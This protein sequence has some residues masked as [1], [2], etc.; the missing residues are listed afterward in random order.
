[1]GG[2]AVGLGVGLALATTPWVA[3]A[4]PMFDDTNDG[5]YGE[6]EAA[7][8]DIG[9]WVNVPAEEAA[10]GGDD[11][12]DLGDEIVDDQVEGAGYADD[13]NGVDDWIDVADDI[14][15]AAD[16]VGAGNDVDGWIDLGV[17]EIAYGG[18]E[19]MIQDT[20]NDEVY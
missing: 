10:N 11:W 6:Y 16:K 3:N 13:E 4:A 7:P 20:A 12:V 15:P 1:M 8:N 19:G 18:D 9:G 17:D 5:V 2:L 14:A